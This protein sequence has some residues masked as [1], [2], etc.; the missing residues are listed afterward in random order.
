MS[1]TEGYNICFRLPDGRVGARIT[2]E[3]DEKSVKAYIQ[4]KCHSV[5][6]VSCQGLARPRRP[7]RSRPAG[8][9]LF[10]G[11][12]QRKQHAGVEHREKG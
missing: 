5:E 1:K 3:S 6:I 10:M 2:A 11:M 9:R 8:T 12:D 7:Y 4:E